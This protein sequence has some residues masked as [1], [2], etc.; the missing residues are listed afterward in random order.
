MSTLTNASLIEANFKIRWHVRNAREMSNIQFLLGDLYSSIKDKF[1]RRSNENLGSAP[2]NMVY[3]DYTHKF[4][5]ES[6]YLP[7]IKVG[8]NN[9]KIDISDDYYDWDSF[10]E[11]I[12]ETTKKLN[13]ILVPI[14]NPDHYHLYLQYIDFFEFDFNANNIF[15]FLRDSLNLEV[16]QSF[17]S[18]E[19]LTNEIDLN[20]NYAIE[21][22]E[23]KF[24]FMKG[25][26]DNKIGLIVITEVESNLV[27][28]VESE[29]NDWIG[30]A[31]DECQNSFKNM[32]KGDLYKSFQ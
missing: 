4:Q 22:G 6:V 8:S 10:S 9:L 26:F 27:S 29:I 2:S 11:T 25:R 5:P 12:E 28:P 17:Y 3:D 18:N 30:K 1:P 21:I 15:D 19:G 31:H 13:D 24:G 20:F 16:N 32:T 14:I 23:I 7:S